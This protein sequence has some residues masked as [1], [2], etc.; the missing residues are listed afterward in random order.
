MKRL[1]LML[2]AVLT[3]SAC[4]PEQWRSISEDVASHSTGEIGVTENAKTAVIELPSY[5]SDLYIDECMAT[6][7]SGGAIDLA[8]GRLFPTSAWVMGQ[9]DV[10]ATPDFID[11][12]TD[13]QESTINDCPL[14]TTTDNDG[15]LIC[16][17]FK[18]NAYGV[19]VG[20]AEAG[21]AATYVWTYYNG[22]SM[23]TLTTIAVPTTF[24]AADHVQLFNAP[25][26]WAKDT[27]DAVNDNSV[28]DLSDK[29]CI[30]GVATTASGTTGALANIAWVMGMEK[31]ARQVADQSWL[32]FTPGNA[33][34]L[35]PDEDF[36][37]YFGGT[38]NAANTCNVIYRV[39]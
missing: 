37:C 27:T 24:T 39:R 4:A 13:C 6:N 38:A 25:V 5:A 19:T 17:D 23:A 12:T 1:F 30:Q 32:D 11:D 7:N 26:D 22:T 21:T 28:T 33:L 20:T 36:L 18:F 16:A 35:R 10:S 2:M 15:H 3:V 9:I 34:H 31:I 29:F 8:C 14:Y